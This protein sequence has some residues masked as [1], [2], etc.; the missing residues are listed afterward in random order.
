MSNKHKSEDVAAARTPAA[1]SPGNGE[2]STWGLPP[3]HSVT[4]AGEEARERTHSVERRLCH[5]LLQQALL[6]RALVTIN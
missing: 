2:T 5:P 4:A 3:H 1:A 6:V